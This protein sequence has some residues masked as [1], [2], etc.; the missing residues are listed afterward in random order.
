[1][2]FISKA[3][4]NVGVRGTNNGNTKQHESSPTFSSQQSDRS[5]GWK[6]GHHKCV[7]QWVIIIIVLLLE[8]AILTRPVRWH[9]G[10]SGQEWFERVRFSSG[11]PPTGRQSK[12]GLRQ[13][14][15]NSFVFFQWIQLK[16]W[17]N[18]AR[19]CKQY[20]QRIWG[21]SGICVH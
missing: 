16:R 20:V 4:P 5:H 9:S 1:M 3:I 21:S 15:G 14:M 11:L 12:S 6:V 10:Q 19:K 7:W 17:Q 18:H 8:W 2:G 13:C